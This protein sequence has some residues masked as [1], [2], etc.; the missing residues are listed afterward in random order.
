L[1]KDSDLD[2]L[3]VDMVTRNPARTVRWLDQV[4]S[5]EPGVAA[6]PYRSLIDATERDVRLVLVGG[7]PLVG[8][9]DVLGRLKP[10]VPSRKIGAMMRDCGTLCA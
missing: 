7:D 4:G 1:A 8:D 6:S 9:V 2:R 3:L 5:V 10:G